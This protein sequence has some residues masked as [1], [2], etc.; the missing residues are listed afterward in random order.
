MS[1]EVIQYCTVPSPTAWP[2]P[3]PCA[4]VVLA[5]QYLRCYGTVRYLRWRAFGRWCEPLDAVVLYMMRVVCPK[6]YV[7]C[8]FPHVGMY[9]CIF[10]CT[11]GRRVGLVVVVV[12]LAGLY[13]VLPP[14]GAEQQNKEH[15]G[16]TVL[17]CTVLYHS[18]SCPSFQLTLT[19]L[20][21][22]PPLPSPPNVSPSILPSVRSVPC[23]RTA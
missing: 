8:L 12:V 2:S 9:V 23:H 11:N 13:H 16:H 19:P 15:V 21:P 4:R 14:L 7:L 22:S 10:V 17:Y 5:V 20:P 6:V 18:F 3:F 1:K